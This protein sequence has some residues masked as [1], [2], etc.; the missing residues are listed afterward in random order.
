[1][2]ISVEEEWFGEFVLPKGK[3]NMGSTLIVLALMS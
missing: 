2:G 1:M 3:R